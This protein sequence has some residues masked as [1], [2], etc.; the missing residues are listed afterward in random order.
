[1]RKEMVKKRQ[2]QYDIA[3]QGLIALPIN[4]A[5]IPFSKPM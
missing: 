2:S 5:L 1:M 3:S 4:G